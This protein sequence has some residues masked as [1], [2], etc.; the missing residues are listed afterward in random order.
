MSNPL[1]RLEPIVSRK[2]PT[3]M[4][5]S[6]RPGVVTVEW[7]VDDFFGDP[8]SPDRVI[9]ELGMGGPS[10]YLGG[11]E[12]SVDLT[13]DEL[14][15]YAGS[16]LAVNVGF[17]WDDGVPEWGSIGITLPRQGDG[18]LFVPRLPVTAPGG[19][20]SLAVSGYSN[21]VAILTWTNPI[22]YDKILVRWGIVGGGSIQFERGGTESADCGL[23]FPARTYM[24]QVKGGVAKTLGGYNYSDWSTIEWVSPAG[25]DPVPATGVFVKGASISAVSRRPDFLQLFGT[26]K[27]RRV[28]TSWWHDGEAWAATTTDWRWPSIGGVFPDGAPVSVVSR[29]PDHLDL[30]STGNDGIVYTSWWDITGGWSGREGWAPIG[31]GFPAGAPVSVVSRNP[32]HLDLFIT[33]NDG[34]VYTSWWDTAGEWSGREGWAPIGGGFPA[35]AP[36]SVVSRNPDHLDL[37]STGNDGIVY[38]SWWDTA[39][40]WSGREGWAP[41]GGGF[42]AGAP[43]SVVSRNPDHLD[44]F[45]TGNDGIVYTSWWDTAGEWSGR[46]GWA[47]IGGG[48]PAGAP[49]SVVSRNPDHLDLFSTGRDGIVYTSWW[50]AAGGGWSGYQGWA[51]IGGVFPAGAPVS[52]V[53]R[54]PDHLDLFITGNNGIVYTSWWHTAGEW[55]GL[56]NTWM[57]LGG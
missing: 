21:H 23:I 28:H 34:I 1:H 22:H 7:E 57:A 15:P 49:V 19:P 54:N 27:D 20:K 25:P 55:S 44:L 51:P 5:A 39:G 43:V 17:Q 11:D 3:N 12:R 40:E 14:E 18:Q 56:H 4:T 31:G 50:D 38:T 47:P 37:F 32:D 52:V 30:F 42:P 26:G 53:S 35:G 41:I 46:E 36:V 48:F 29:N 33:G 6:V 24:F 10:K 16:Q 2:P 8:E 45:I 9:V 13:A